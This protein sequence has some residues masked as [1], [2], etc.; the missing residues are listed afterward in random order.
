MR[1]ACWSQVAAILILFHLELISLFCQFVIDDHF[2]IETQ[3]LY[4]RILFIFRIKGPIVQLDY[5]ADCGLKFNPV[6]SLCNFVVCLLLRNF[7][8]E[9]RLT[10]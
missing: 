9:N 10:H 4:V 8:E 5:S 3:V 7:K 6:F 1:A 2:G